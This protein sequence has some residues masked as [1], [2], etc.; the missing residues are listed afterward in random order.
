MYLGPL[1]LDFE[2]YLPRFKTF[3]RDVYR[4]TAIEHEREKH[5]DWNTTAVWDEAQRTFDESAKAF[6]EVGWI[7]ELIIY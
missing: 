4:E 1:V 7:Y 5:P 6:I 3:M 2:E